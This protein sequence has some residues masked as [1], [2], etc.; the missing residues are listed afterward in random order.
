MPKNLSRRGVL[1]AFAGGSIGLAVASLSACGATPKPAATTAAQAGATS[2]GKA[3]LNYWTGWSGFEFDALQKIVDKFNAANPD[4]FVNMTT[5]F[6]QYDKVLTAIAGGNPPDVVSA[7]WLQQL[8]SMA[9]RDGLIPLEAYAD[10]D[11]I[12]GSAYFKNCWDAWH[13]DGHLWGLAITVNA[14]VLAYRRDIFKEVGLNPDTPPKTI[15]DLDAETK[16]LDK[17]DANGNIQRYGLMPGGLFWW[18]LVFGGN[19]YDENNKKVTANDPKIVEALK[20][21][22]T[23]AKKLD[24]TKVEAFQA[25]FGDY[26]SP[27]NA[28]FVGKEVISQVGEWFIS[29]VNKYAPGLDYDFMSAPAPDGGRPDCTTFGGSV[30]TIPKGAKNPDASWRFIKFVSED[31]NMGEFAFTIHNIPPKTKVANES[32]FIDD[33]KFKKCVDLYTGKNVF[34]PPKTPVTDFYFTKMDEAESAV[35]HGTKEP[36][37]ALDELTK[38][39]QDELDKALKH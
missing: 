36:Q 20:W 25:G 5:V 33:P 13:Y 28:F 35:K 11:K 2:G 27:Q 18:G 22:L 10:K 15:T 1:R 12:D 6:G 30:F 24:I 14:N 17:I 3:F 29:F 7:V 21:M 31:E 9:A 16:A 8:V 37:A 19:F 34:G 26:M 23:Y 4:V 38:L 39:V 32:R